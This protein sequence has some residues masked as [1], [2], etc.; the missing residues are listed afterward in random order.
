MNGSSEKKGL[1]ASWSNTTAQQQRRDGGVGHRAMPDLAA[2][3][4]ERGR[5]GCEEGTVP[6]W[7]HADCAHER[8]Q[9]VGHIYHFIFVGCMQN[10]VEG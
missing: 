9:G 10:I 5:R 8:K 4:G 3:K 6:T 2:P 7:S 1:P